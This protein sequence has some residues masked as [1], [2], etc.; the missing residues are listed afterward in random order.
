MPSF[1]FNSYVSL[2]HA[3]TFQM[4]VRFRTHTVAVDGGDITQDGTESAPI[5]KVK[6]IFHK[7]KK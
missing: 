5:A 4:W 2:I 3:Y 7:N 6:Q 1:S